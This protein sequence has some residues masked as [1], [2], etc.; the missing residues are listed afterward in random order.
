MLKT[1]KSLAIPFLIGGSV[2]SGV[3]YSAT[4]MDNPGLAAIIGGVPTGLVSIILLQTRQK[5]SDYAENYF[6]VTLSL[7]FSIAF[8]YFM[9]TKTKISYKTIWILSIV[10][11]SILVL[12]HYFLTKKIKNS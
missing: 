6:F 7:L 9:V 4:H 8:Y 10:F 11:W 3:K 2:I 12:L 5:S 1:L